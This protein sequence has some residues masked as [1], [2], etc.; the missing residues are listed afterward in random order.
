[1]SN[2]RKQANDLPPGACDDFPQRWCEVTFRV[3]S[4]N[5]RVHGLRSFDTVQ[6][7]LENVNRDVDHW[8]TLADTRGRTTGYLYLKA[9]GPHLF[10]ANKPEAPTLNSHEDATC[11]TRT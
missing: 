10:E 11:L 9:V 1:M 4:E 5:G 8:L 2:H 3:P 7:Y 6:L